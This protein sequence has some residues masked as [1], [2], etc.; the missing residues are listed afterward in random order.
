VTAPGGIVWEAGFWG[1]RGVVLAVGGAPVSGGAIGLGGVWGV[2]GGGLSLEMLGMGAVTAVDQAGGAPVE[3]VGTNWPEVPM[4]RVVAAETF[5]LGG[6]LIFPVA[7][8]R[9]RGGR[10]IRNVSRFGAFGSDPWGVAESAI[11]F[12]FIVIS[13]NVQ[14]RNSQWQRIYEVNAVLA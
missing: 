5:G 12:L 13:G 10:L 3:G 6:V 8:R 14:W 11:M 7:G 1:K 4:G 2:T 9:G